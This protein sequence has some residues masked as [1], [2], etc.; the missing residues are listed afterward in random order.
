M[1]DNKALFGCSVTARRTRRARYCAGCRHNHT[2][3]DTSS[4][5]LLDEHYIRA[6]RDISWITCGYNIYATRSEISL[7]SIWLGALSKVVADRLAGFRR[8]LRNSMARSPLQNPLSAG[9]RIATPLRWHSASMM[10]SV[11]R[12]AT[13]QCPSGREGDPSAQ[14]MEV[15]SGNMPTLRTAGKLLCRHG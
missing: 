11:Q 2:V 3:S 15:N 10:E 1:N 6:V 7:T 4:L 13:T 8:C 12:H 14:R 5:L 9:S